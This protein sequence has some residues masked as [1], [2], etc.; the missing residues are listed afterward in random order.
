MSCL[1]T[2]GT[3]ICTC[4]APAVPRKPRWHEG[5]RIVDPRLRA[6]RAEGRRRARHTGRRA[7]RGGRLRRGRQA[8]GGGAGGCC[9][10]RARTEGSS[11]HGS[12]A[13]EPRSRCA[14]GLGA[15]DPLGRR[16]QGAGVT[17]PADRT[18]EARAPGERRAGRPG[19]GISPRP[20]RGRPGSCDRRIRVTRNPSPSPGSPS[21]FAVRPEAGTGAVP[22]DPWRRPGRAR[23]GAYDGSP[24]RMNAAQ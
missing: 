6:D 24:M 2:N 13:T 17:A 22:P 14:R 23:P 1:K 3:G 19:K 10:R 7:R 9:P 8:G 15:I 5:L 12:S 18:P 21:A 11:V 4:H 20:A 16:G